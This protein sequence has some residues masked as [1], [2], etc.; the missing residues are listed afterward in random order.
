MV[1]FNKPFPHL[2]NL[3]YFITEMEMRLQDQEAMMN[4]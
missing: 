4:K 1:S 3:K 2:P